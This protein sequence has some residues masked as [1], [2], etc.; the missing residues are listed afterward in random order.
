MIYILLTWIHNSINVLVF[1]PDAHFQMKNSAASNGLNRPY[2]VLADILSI[3][4]A[5]I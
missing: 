2:E 4:K 1:S 3:Y 5:M